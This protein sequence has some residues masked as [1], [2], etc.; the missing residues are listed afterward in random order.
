MVSGSSIRPRSR[1]DDPIRSALLLGFVFAALYFLTRSPSLD[2]WDSV[3]FALG[4][5]DFNL[6]RHQPHPPGYPLYIGAG[7]LFSHGL[8][9]DAP[10]ALQL[11]SALGGG[12][13]ITCW[14]IMVRRYFRAS[15]AWL[16]ALTLGCLLI[17]WM[18]ATKV[19]TDPWGAGLLA[20]TLALADAD[21]RPA[22]AGFA[23]A[24][25]VGARPQNFVVVVLILCLA[26]WRS[27]HGRRVWAASLG[28]FFGG[29]LC[30]LVPVAWLQARTPEAHGNPWA[31]GAQLL[32]QWQWRMDQPKVYLAA[33]GQS[34][35][36]LQQ[37]FGRH[38]L[39][40]LARGFGFPFK[41]L[42]GWAGVTML[43]LGWT[44]HGLQAIRGETNVRAFWARQWPWAFAYIA[45]VF[46]CL[47][48]DQRYYLPIY[49][50]LAFAAVAGFQSLPGVWR[51]SAVIVPASALAVT[52][53]FI[54]VNHTDLAPPVEIMR[55]LDN[56]HPPAERGA[57]W[58][59]L[60][61]NRR[62]AD[63]YAADFHI[64]R[65]ETFDPLH[66]PAD[67][68]AAR[69]IYT[70]DPAIVARPPAGKRWRLMCSFS[71]SPLIYR[72]HNEATLWRLAN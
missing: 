57:V 67:W 64:I 1:L 27:G 20:L 42:W 5:G 69:T 68:T 36:M 23:G 29:C 59:I 33:K 19:L 25:A 53:P 24:A 49:P 66:W 12:L 45:V 22:L 13:S 4:V 11:V 3:Q 50:L 61:D 16:T 34:G 37:R 17:T 60:R 44:F 65:A 62:H 58:L 30:W 46:A 2:E 9:L 26:A 15:T 56:T 35:T 51:W 40:W 28:A 7:W 8:G 54:G 41:K 48:G 14:F 38:F 63:W 43:T 39:D 6:W 10:N 55:Y 70:D 21:N 71:R 47:P 72:K 31:Y 52:L 32:H 18:C